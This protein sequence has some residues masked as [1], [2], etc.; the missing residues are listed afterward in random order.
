M[1]PHFMLIG[2]EGITILI[3]QKIKIT[4]LTIEV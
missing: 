1:K 4:E 3:I 2:G